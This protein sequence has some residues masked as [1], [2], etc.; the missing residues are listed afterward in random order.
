MAPAGF[1]YYGDAEEVR[2]LFWAELQKHLPD[3]G[4][5]S[6]LDA[7]KLARDLGV[8]LWHGIA[9]DN[10]AI[11]RVVEEDRD[12]EEVQRLDAFLHLSGHED[13]DWI[14]KI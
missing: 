12:I 11:D 7:V 4:Q 3:L 1:Q 5:K 6:V 13:L 8:L 9:F 14:S 2:A 10:G